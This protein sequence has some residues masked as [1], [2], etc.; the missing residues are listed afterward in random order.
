MLGMLRNVMGN[1]GFQLG[2]EFYLKNNSYKTATHQDLWNAMSNVMLQKYY[3]QK[4]NTSVP[5][6]ILY[7]R[8]LTLMEYLVGMVPKLWMFQHS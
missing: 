1:S 2:L 5:I 7:F 6:M 3:C 8:Q 4:T